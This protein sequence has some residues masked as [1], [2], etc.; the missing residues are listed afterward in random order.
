MARRLRAVLIGGRGFEP[1]E[2]LYKH[3]IPSFQKLEDVEV[4]ILA[5]YPHPDLNR[6]KDSFP[7]SLGQVDVISSHTSF[8]RSY[9]HLYEDLSSYFDDVYKDLLEPLKKACVIGG[10]MLAIPRFIDVRTLHYRTDVVEDP[11]KSW[12]E[13]VETARS[14]NKPPDLYGFAMVGYGHALVGSFMEILRSFGGE[15][16]DEKT[17]DCLF[18]GREGVEALEYIVDLNRKHRVTPPETPQY[19]Y[20]HVSESFSSGRAAM[21]FEWPGWDMAHNDP[22]R[23]KVAGL[24]DLALYPVG[25]GGRWVYGGSHAFSIVKGSRE[26]ELAARFIRFLVSLENQVFEAEEEGFLPSRRSSWDLLTRRAREKGDL[27]QLK[28]LEIYGRTIDESYLP[29]KIREW[30]RFTEIMWPE[31]NAA[32][33]GAVDPANALKRSYDRIVGDLGG[34]Y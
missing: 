5:L 33:R 32:L 3:A 10:K 19:F 23:S 2:T 7:G 30:R 28:R 13:L 18:A 24:F 26:P 14:V 12:E 17:G 9:A 1:Y 34:C 25:R 22:K 11:P 8:L 29:V 21:V 20:N 4:E 16:S 6:F 27:F 15:I 31:L